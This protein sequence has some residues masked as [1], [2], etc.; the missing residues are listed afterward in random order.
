MI[1]STA[2]GI[3]IWYEL[4]TIDSKA[5]ATFYAQV[6]GWKSREMNGPSGTYTIVST[7][8]SDVG[9]IMA[10]PAEAC[11]AGARPG[12]VTYIGVDDVD[13][14]AKKAKAAGGSIQRPPDEIPGVGRFAVVADPGGAVFMMMTP[15]SKEPLPAVAPNTPGHVGWRELH[16]ANG[17]EAWKFYS[18]L[19][20]WTQAEAMDMG[21]QGVY[22][23][24]TT[25]GDAIGGMM[26]KMPEAPAPFWMFYFNVEA[27]DLASD[28][29]SKAG[30]KLIHGPMQVP[31]GSWIANYID[32]Q[33]AMFSLVSQ[34]R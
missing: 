19:F 33:N 31:G 9:G 24:F 3:F 8:E 34:K 7:T 12:W 30:G 18:E 10:L 32:P 5:A 13:A 11:A 15:L 23:T 29:V 6:L 27:L 1:T 25:G 26:T 21:P 22:Q 14:F 17:A 20:G 2:K 4:C 16:A 28:R